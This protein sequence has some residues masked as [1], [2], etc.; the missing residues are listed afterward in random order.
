M[1]TN[2]LFDNW[3]DTQEQDLLEDLIVEAI[4][5]YGY[6][7][8]YLPRTLV[9]LDP[10]FGE[11]EVSRFDSAIQCEMY[12]MNT[13]GFSGAGTFM[14]FAGAPEIRDRLTFAMSRRRFTELLAPTLNNP[15]PKEGD[16]IYLGL[17]GGIYEIKF[18]EQER[19]FYQLGKLNTYELVCELFEYSDEEFRTG[20]PAI[21]SI[22]TTYT[23]DAQQD[24]LIDNAGNYILISDG[25]HL[26]VAD[27]P[28]STNDPNADN[29][30]LEDAA[31]GIIDFSIT[32]PF[33]E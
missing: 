29:Q 30:E 33:S 18:V 5:M 24:D 28:I 19:S 6:D 12:I 8:Y 22:E 21:D 10:I 26:T 9:N 4:Q 23:T 1:P 15:R 31:A 14:A 16:L 20:I 13:Q 7:C 17:T 25:S 2:P 3:N 27:T 11:E 32:N